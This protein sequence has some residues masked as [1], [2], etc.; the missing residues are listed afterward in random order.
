MRGNARIA[1]TASGLVQP[2]RTIDSIDPVEHQVGEHPIP[3]KGR[4]TL[5]G[6]QGPGLKFV[7][8]PARQ[9]NR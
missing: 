4:I 1:A 7:D 2:V 6:T 3:V 9:T 8:D 5:V